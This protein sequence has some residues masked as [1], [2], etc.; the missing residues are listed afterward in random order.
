MTAMAAF[1]VSLPLASRAEEDS[2]Q[3]GNNA[4]LLPTNYTTTPPLIEFPT[5][6]IAYALGGL[7]Q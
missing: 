3:D 1:T 5:F 6:W 7:E 2:A 4:P